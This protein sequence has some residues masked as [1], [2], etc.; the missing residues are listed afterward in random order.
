MTKTILITGAT[1][2]IGEASA[3]K[4]ATGGWKVIGTGRRAD[5]LR[6]LADEL[7]E[8]FLPL[9]IDMRDLDSVRSLAELSP[10]WG[11]IDLLLNNAGLAPP[12]DPLP[13]TDW[14]LLET[15]METNMTGL[16]A[17]T[18]ALLPGLIERKGG[19]INLSSVAA[20]Y[21]YKG[22]AVYGGTKAF[23]RQFSLDLRCDLAG[24]GV[25]VTSIE[26]GMVETEFTIVRTGGDKAASDALYANMDPMTAEDIA[27][28]IWWVANLPPHVNVNAIELMPTSQSFAGFTISRKG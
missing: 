7:G 14:E 27:E 25:R 18:R 5:R 3:R 10:P 20:T 11:E 4:F 24:T 6:D 21:P 9:E 15:V 28:S 1:A 19:I 2:G 12:T 17:L 13:E 23:V 26:P 8:S 16:V 22:G